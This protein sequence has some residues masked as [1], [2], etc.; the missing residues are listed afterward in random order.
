MGVYSVKAKVA[1]LIFIRISNALWNRSDAQ[2]KRL[3][4]LRASAN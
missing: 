2:A 3:Y 1:R 4:G